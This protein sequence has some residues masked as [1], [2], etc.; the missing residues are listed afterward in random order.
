MDI[1]ALVVAEMAGRLTDKVAEELHVM[2]VSLVPVDAA[3]ADAV[4]AVVE[5]TLQVSRQKVS[6]RLIVGEL[7]GH[8]VDTDFA[9]YLLDWRTKT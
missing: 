8:V 4:A 3:S 7:V 9:L 2:V 5:G 1:V 6:T